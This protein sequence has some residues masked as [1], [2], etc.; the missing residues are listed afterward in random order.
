MRHGRRQLS[1]LLCAAALLSRIAQAHDAPVQLPPPQS[2]A[3]AWNVIEQC[4]ANVDQLLAENLMR[5]VG[6][7]LAN[8]SV[9]LRYLNQ[10]ANGDKAEQIRQIS[11]KLIS[12]EAE[13]L[14]DSRLADG[15]KQKTSDAWRQW[16]HELAAL[17]TLYPAESVRADVFICP[18]H[19]TDR[20]LNPADKCTVC[21]M[22]LVRRR[23]PASSVY[24]RPGDPTLKI[25][26]T[27]PPLR[28]GEPAKVVIRLRR[29]DGASVTPADLIETHTRK[30]H[31]LIN[32]RSLGDYHHEHP[33]PTP[34]PGEYE[35][36]FTP[37]RPGPYRIWA[38]LVPASTGVQEYDVVDL[39]A[40]SAS[41]PI[42]DRETRLTQVAGGQRFALT[43]LANGQ[44]LRAGQTYVGTINVTGADGKPFTALE[45]VM[46][47]FAHLVGFGEDGKSILHVHPSGKEPTGPNDRAGPDFAFKFYAPSNGFLRLYCQVHVDGKDVF[48]PFNLN[49]AP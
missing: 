28:V 43:F 3:E 8:L 2:A 16:L 5:D 20:H 7:Q 11:A 21:G 39:P 17:E 27:C 34:T 33:T 1:I 14:G 32:D 23:L 41:Q 6:G 38:D 15:A 30:I 26:A 25:E 36:S 37:A 45:P 10:N 24:Q 35:F 12:A 47:A 4:K 22:A 31:L 29:S 48:V 9:A 19:P 46:G 44:P 13:L 42:A 40:D 18:M 49:V